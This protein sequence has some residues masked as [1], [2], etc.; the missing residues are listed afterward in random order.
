M[1]LRRRRHQQ[2]GTVVP[3]PPPAPP[4]LRA[5]RSIRPRRSARFGTSPP[6]STPTPTPHDFA[7]GAQPAAERTSERAEERQ[8][9]GRW[10]A[11]AEALTPEAVVA[12]AT[13]A[14]AQANADDADTC[15]VCLGG[16]GAVDA[17]TDCDGPA[18]Q[19]HLCQAPH[20]FHA[21]CARQALA[22]L[23]RCP[24][25]LVPFGVLEGDRP[26]GSMSVRRAPPERG[27]LPG[28]DGVGILEITYYFP[29]GTQTAKHPRPGTAYSGTVRT[30]Y[31]PDSAQGR[32]VLRRLQLAWD[33]RLIF[34]I[35]RS[36]TTGRDNTVVWSGIHH[37]TS[38]YGGAFGYPDPTYL[39]RVTDELKGFGV[40]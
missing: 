27:S 26:D 34:T 9:P 31:L 8:D 36:V 18:L 21:D 11:P 30:A 5:P 6:V 17:A 3:P 10:F 23:S 20:F 24:V 25:C 19:L 28:H 14:T 38:P 1:D 33:R 32:D 2:G 12:Q 7:S 40:E 4:P 29:S 22:S 16:F 15:A 39:D 13:D 35:G 37:K